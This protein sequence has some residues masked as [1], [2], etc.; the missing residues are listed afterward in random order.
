MF[1]YIGVLFLNNIHDIAPSPL[2][3]FVCLLNGQAYRV[4]YHPDFNYSFSTIQFTNLITHNF[5]SG[6]S[7]RCGEI[8]DRI[9]SPSI[10]LWIYPVHYI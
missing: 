2:L 5:F 1:I 3:S 7:L 9:W 8:A 10:V 6:R 4:G